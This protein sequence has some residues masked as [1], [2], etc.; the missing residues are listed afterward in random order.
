MSVSK[1]GAKIA[2]F[3]EVPVGSQISVENPVH[4]A[5]GKARV[6]RING[7]GHREDPY[8]ISIELA[9]AKDVWGVKFPPEDWKQGLAL[10]KDKWA[11][12][13]AVRDLA[14]SAAVTQAPRAESPSPRAVGQSTAELQIEPESRPSPAALPS[15]EVTETRREA[16]PKTPTPSPDQATSEGGKSA[17]PELPSVQPALGVLKE[18]TKPP[19]LEQESS[20]LPDRLELSRRALE[21]LLAEVGKVQQGWQAEVD[22]A[23]RDVQ[24][25][26]WQAVE[27]ALQGSN[28]KLR[29]DIEALSSVAVTDARKRIQEEGSATVEAIRKEIASRLD[30]FA[31]GYLLNLAV[32]LDTRQ[33][34][35]NE[36]TKERIVQLIGTAVAEFADRTKKLGNEAA[37]S[38]R[39]Q[40]ERSLETAAREVVGRLTSSIQE[41]IQ[42]AVQ[43][44]SRSL[45]ENIRKMHERIQG[46][47]ASVTLKAQKSCQQGADAART[48]AAGHVNTIVEQAVAKMQAAR[49]KVEFGFGGQ[50]EEHQKRL[51]ELAASFQEQFRQYAETQ[52]RALEGE[53][54]ETRRASQEKSAEE[55][56]GRLEKVAEELLEL[57]AKQLRQQVDDAL[58]LAKDGLKNSAQEF[59]DDTRNQLAAEAR[60]NLDSLR[61]EADAI[62]D[63]LKTLGEEQRV[64]EKVDLIQTE[65][66]LAAMTRE[67]LESLTTGAKTASEQ[68]QT[69]LQT[70][71]QDFQ[72]RTVRELESHFQKTL[73]KQSETLLARLQKETELA[74]ERAAAQIRSNSETVAEE[75][76]EKV[77]K[78]LG[79]AT[80][81]LKDWTDQAATRLEG[82]LRN[83]LEAFEKRIGELSDAALNLHREKTRV[84]IDDLHKRLQQAARVLHGSETVDPENPD[85]SK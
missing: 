73:E 30:S 62:R 31:E 5:S 83:S 49:Q 1:H 36:Q 51:A 33:K 54:Q 84:Q 23:R 16:V 45:Q 6:V 76:S 8:E 64:A 39:A 53:L 21:A 20:G 11:E 40:T 61:Q 81:V 59:I 19:S 56:S 26:G 35:A 13:R 32:Q 68:Y 24:D 27:F 58:E 44:E 57:L 46:E 18:K 41:Q 77:Y 63:E 60:S 14:P 80:V 82:S 85:D 28:E 15:T 48:A 52:T 4:G 75:A 7:K 17:M 67:V 3:H 71:L 2:T 55:A 38:L 47:L 9:E 37:A 69:Q 25:A 22:R 34:Q 65:E 29:Q 43:A 72:N 66:R 12:Q 10:G 74:S 42:S 78:Q 50:V 70:A 79:L